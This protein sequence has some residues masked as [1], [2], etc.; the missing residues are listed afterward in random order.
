MNECMDNG[1]EDKQDISFVFSSQDESIVPVS[2]NE[3][4]LDTLSEGGSYGSNVDF[5]ISPETNTGIHFLNMKYSQVLLVNNEEPQESIFHD[6]AIP[7]TIKDE[8]SITIH[9]N[10]P[11][12]IFTNAEFPFEVEVTSED[13]DILDVIISKDLFPKLELKN[14]W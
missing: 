14:K 11:E 7:I 5:M 9:T 10:T 13:I 6:I 3:L 2:S 4:I 8:P 12:S 1:W